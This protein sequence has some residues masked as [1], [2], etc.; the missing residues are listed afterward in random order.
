MKTLHGRI[1]QL[2]ELP[3]MQNSSVKELLAEIGVDMEV[4]HTEEHLISWAGLA[5]AI[6]RAQEKKF[7]H[8]LRQ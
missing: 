5:P 6:T 2:C 4:F 8:Q 3:G 7:T 1:D